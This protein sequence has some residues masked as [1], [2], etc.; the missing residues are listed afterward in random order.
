MTVPPQAETP[1]FDKKVTDAATEA[2]KVSR[3]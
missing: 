2:A 1:L 3:S